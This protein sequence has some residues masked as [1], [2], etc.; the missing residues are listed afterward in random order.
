M[1]QAHGQRPYHADSTGSHLNTKVKQ[2]RAG[3]VPGWET[4]WETPVLLA[5]NFWPELANFCMPATFF[6]AGAGR[7][8]P[9]AFSMGLW[10]I[11]YLS[12]LR[13]LVETSGCPEA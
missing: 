1:Q 6:A 7:A 5:L 11:S 2:H 10:Y 13:R 9:N 12:Y 3:L 4:T 8:R